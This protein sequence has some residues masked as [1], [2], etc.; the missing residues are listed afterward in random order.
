M[1]DEVDPNAVLAGWKPED[2]PAPYEHGEPV[3]PLAE[4]DTREGLPAE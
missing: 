1:T 3:A 4:A 2:G